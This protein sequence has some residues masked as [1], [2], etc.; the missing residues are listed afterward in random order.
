M[1]KAPEKV[2]YSPTTCSLALPP[3]V[4]DPMLVF[5]HPVP[6]LY[7]FF[8]GHFYLFLTLFLI[9]SECCGPWVYCWGGETLFA[10]WCCQRLWG[11]IRSWEGQGR[12]GKW[13]L[14]SHT[15]LLKLWGTYQHS[16]WNVGPC[17]FGKRQGSDCYHSLAPSPGW[18]PWPPQ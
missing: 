16:H 8:P 15:S 10:D 12:Q 13:Q 11:Q 4:V 1:C 5:W 18:F 17:F 6:S 2:T 9:F 7:L 3:E 14:S